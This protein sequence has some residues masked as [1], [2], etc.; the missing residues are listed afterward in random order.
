MEKVTFKGWQNCYK[1]ASNFVDLIVT[2]DV[3]PRIIHFSFPGDDN[4][5]A[6][7]PDQI[8]QTGGDD[9][10]IYGGHRLWH[11][12][13]GRTRTYYPDNNPVEIQELEKGVRLIAPVEPTTGIQKEID[14]FPSP[15]RARVK[16]VHRL[17]NHNMWPIELAPW[18]LSVMATGGTAVLPLP[19]GG[20]HEEDLLPVATIVLWPYTR[21]NDPR[22]TWGSEY[23]LLHQDTSAEGP[24]KI[25]ANNMHGW[26]GYVNNG[27]FFLKTFPKH[28][29]DLAYADKGSSTELFT[30]PTFLE[31]ESLGPLVNLQPKAEVEHVEEWYLFPDVE[32]PS[33]DADVNEHVLPKV[34]SIL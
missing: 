26:S 18:A 19:E 28:D 17:R 27:C 6:E 3:G 15:N 33:N 20:S 1:I 13:E 14:I 10:R 34:K 4:V 16:V 23:I 32:T 5:F 9:W 29:L 7:F 30:D 21:M 8:G 12:P 24:Q 25:G 11:A 2:T 31:V 22:W